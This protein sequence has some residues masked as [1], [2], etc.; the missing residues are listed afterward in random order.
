[1]ALTERQKTAIAE[2]LAATEAFSAKARHLER[3]AARVWA[4]LQQEPSEHPAGLDQ[5][6]RS[7]RE[8]LNRTE[9]R[10]DFEFERKRLA[11]AWR[12]FRMAF[13]LTP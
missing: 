7:V 8:L 9:S 11:A 12:E 10:K 3:S 6:E 13:T 1:M 4:L 2:L 5:V